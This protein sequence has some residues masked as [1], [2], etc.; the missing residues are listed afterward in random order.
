MG[1]R[2]RGADQN[3]S[4]TVSFKNQGSCLSELYEWTDGDQYRERT[5][6]PVRNEQEPCKAD[7]QRSDRKAEFG[8]CRTSAEGCRSR[9]IQM[10]GIYGSERTG[11]PQKT[12]RKDFQLERAAGN[13]RR[14][15]LPP[16]KR[17]PV[18]VL[19]YSGV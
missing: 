6:T 18:Q 14:Q 11:E 8:H 15:A 2:K 1:F 16:W 7:R 5:A 19:R 12:G 3:R 9:A 13:R 4:D 17:L 10:V